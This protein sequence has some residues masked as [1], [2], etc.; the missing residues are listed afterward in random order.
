MISLFDFI[1]IN[2]VKDY[3]IPLSKMGDYMENNFPTICATI[4]SQNKVER[5]L[6]NESLH[7][8]NELNKYDDIHL[9]YLE[10]K[11]KN[12]GEFL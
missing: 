12:K 7:K 4:R 6:V 2:E 10:E 8:L 3:P 9:L 1:N 11:L 5:Y